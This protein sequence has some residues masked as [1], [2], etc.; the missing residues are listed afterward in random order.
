M[1]RAIAAAAGAGAVLLLLF[2]VQ[3]QR[4]HAHLGGPAG[5]SVVLIRAEDQQNAAGPILKPVSR[6]VAGQLAAVF[7]WQQYWEASRQ[8]LAM[9]GAQSARV[10]LSPECEVEIEY[11]SPALR[12]TR[13]Y[14]NGVLATRS[15][16]HV[17]ASSPAID[18]ASMDADGAWF[19]LVRDEW[20][21]N[22]N[23]VSLTRSVGLGRLPIIYCFIGNRSRPVVAAA[24]ELSEL[25]VFDQYTSSLA[26]DTLSLL[27]AMAIPRETLV[28]GRDFGPRPGRDASLID[29]PRA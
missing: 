24:L 3:L 19:V 16:R 25:A 11:L 22:V 27:N 23:V 14:V 13:I 4:R 12:E 21:Q 28:Q 26:A 15:R 5:C 10:R 18:G 8:H 6:D 17:R 29:S 7:H 1:T 2:T 9:Q 20:P